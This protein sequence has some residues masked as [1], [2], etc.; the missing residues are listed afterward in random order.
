MLLIAAVFAVIVVLWI[1][2]AVLFYFM[3]ALIAVV[4]FGL[5][6]LGRWSSS[7]GSRT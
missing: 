3:I 6:R 4:G 5:F 7:R 1:I 2:H